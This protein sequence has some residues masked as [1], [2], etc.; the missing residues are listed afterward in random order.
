MSTAEKT[1][2]ATGGFTC[3]DCGRSF[4][5]PQGLS[6]HRAETHGAVSARSRAKTAKTATTPYDAD[7]YRGLAR[8]LFDDADNARKELAEHDAKRA[9]LAERVRRL[10]GAIARLVG[11][12]ATPKKTTAGRTTTPE[13]IAYT[14]QFLDAHR[15]ELADGFTA[16]S[17]LKAIRANGG[18]GPSERRV[19]Q[20]IV[21]LH[22]RGVIR[23]DKKT[24]GGGN[25][26]KL[27]G[28]PDV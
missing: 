6:R 21:E 13:A 9:A 27:I 17:L 2:E 25:L 14:E 15:D 19:S 22:A 7:Y 12:P 3:P 5:R 4:S 11:E 16:H 26:Y 24:L 28:A 10:D 20:A 23:L 18:G 8:P 1:N